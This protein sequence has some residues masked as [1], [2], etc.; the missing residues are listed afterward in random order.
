[1]T[2]LLVIAALLAIVL[3]AAAIVTVSIP[4]YCAVRAVLLRVEPELF[5]WMDF[6]E[7]VFGGRKT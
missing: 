1:M 3:L 2:I 5:W 7:G 6:W 4:I